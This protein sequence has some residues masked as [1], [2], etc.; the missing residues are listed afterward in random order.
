MC[1]LALYVV[2]IQKHICISSQDEGEMKN[3]KEKV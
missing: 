1:N 3:V 2:K